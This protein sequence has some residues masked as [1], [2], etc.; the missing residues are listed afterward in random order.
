MK[1]LTWYV[2]PLFQ[3]PAQVKFDIIYNYSFFVYIIISYGVGSTNIRYSSLPTL[4]Y[5]S[6]PTN[7]GFINTPTFVGVGV[8]VGVSV[9]VGVGV[10]VPIG[11]C[12][13]VFVTVAVT[14]GVGVGVSGIVGVGVGVIGY[15]YPI[16]NTSQFVISCGGG[17]VEPEKPVVDT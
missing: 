11:V 14:D 4:K 5:S 13:G 15:W 1:V 17:V 16:T 10:W 6:T 3:K 9:K 8:G 2:V 12:D 7:N